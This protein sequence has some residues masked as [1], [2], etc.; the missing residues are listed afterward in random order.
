MNSYTHGYHPTV[1]QT[2]RMR[3][4]ENSAAYLLPHLAPG[5][6]LLDVGSGAGTIT[7]GFVPLV[8]SVTALEYNDEA[9]ALT[10]AELAARGLVAEFV[11]DD[12][13]GLS[14]DDDSFDVVHAHQVIQHVADPVRA[15]SEMMRV[16]R[17]GGVVAIRDSDYAAFTWFPANPGLTNWMDTYQAV[18]RSNGGE[19]NA[20]RMLKA[21]A[22]KAGA[23][24][25]TCSSSTW[26]FASDDERGFWGGNWERRVLESKFE[27]DALA[28]GVADR[29]QLETIS[30]A[31]RTWI[32]DADG[33]FMVPHG[34]IL[35]R[36]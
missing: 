9:I 15:I 24:D 20:G 21:W 5:Q 1:L 13:L 35:I 32:E 3:T 23:T 34:E 7:A 30:A 33:W 6:D 8:G 10:R 36:C 22:R 2:H 11:V 19:P 29:I 17:P 25:V 18:A 4:V 28:L 12:V 14:F 27:S 16:C 26:T 31:W